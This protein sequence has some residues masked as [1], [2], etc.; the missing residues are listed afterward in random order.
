MNS[1][2]TSSL[3]F[4]KQLQKNNHRDW[5]TEHKKEYQASEKALKLVYA[6][7]LDGLNEEDEI[8]KLKVFRINRDIR[9]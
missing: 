1:I 4:L 7:I 3:T 5:M 9:F 8:Q 2:P 6:D